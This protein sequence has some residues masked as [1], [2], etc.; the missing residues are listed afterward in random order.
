[1]AAWCP[2]S[3]PRERRM[4]DTKLVLAAMTSLLC[5]ASAASGQ[6]AP[7]E[8]AAKPLEI[9]GQRWGAK[10]SQVVVRTDEAFASLWAE[11]TRGM[12][13]PP[14]APKVDFKKYDVIGVFAG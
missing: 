14:A 8:P 5:L 13:I 3:W 4:L 11:H 7:A 6:G 1:M 9:A 10:A 12:V 2:R